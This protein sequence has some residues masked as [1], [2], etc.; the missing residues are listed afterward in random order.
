MQCKVPYFVS[1]GWFCWY[2]VVKPR[3]TGTSCE[4]GKRKRQIQNLEPGMLIQHPKG[5]AGAPNY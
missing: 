5:W 2:L 3:F 1:G 4:T